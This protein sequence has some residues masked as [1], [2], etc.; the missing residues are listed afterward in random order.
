VT[1]RPQ[2]AHFCP[3]HRNGRGPG[4]PAP[5]PCHRTPRP[6]GPDAAAG[7]PATTTGR[8]AASRRERPGARDTRSDA[9]WRHGGRR[10]GWPPVAV[11]AQGAAGESRAEPGRPSSGPAGPRPAGRHGTRAGRR[12]PRWPSP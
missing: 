1:G 12:A 10:L 11:S 6:R 5:R 3:V 2:G 9:E 7:R 4:G 8:H